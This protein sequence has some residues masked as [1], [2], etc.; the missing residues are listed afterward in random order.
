ML[1]VPRTSRSGQ[2]EGWDTESGNQPENCCLKQFFFDDYHSPLR[3]RFYRSEFYRGTTQEIASEPN[4]D[5][6]RVLNKLKCE[7]LCAMAPDLLSWDC[8]L[9]SD[10]A[11]YDYELIRDEVNGASERN[12]VQLR[13]TSKDKFTSSIVADKNYLYDFKIISPTLPVSAISNNRA[14]SHSFTKQF[15]SLFFH[16][17]D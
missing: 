2:F 11:D 15:Y 10:P 8:D 17:S 7:G 12:D 6:E 5:C 3:S 16:N 14:K 1:S 4:N 9:K 13:A